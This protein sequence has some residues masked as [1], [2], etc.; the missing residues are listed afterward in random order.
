MEIRRRFRLEWGV[1]GLHW[2]KD[3]GI[4]KMAGWTTFWEGAAIVILKPSLMSALWKTWRTVREIKAE[5][6]NASN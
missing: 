5:Q 4:D 1:Y 6:V 3:Y 2:D